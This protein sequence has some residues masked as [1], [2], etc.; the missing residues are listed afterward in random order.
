MNSLN[1]DRA[2]ALPHKEDIHFRPSA[3]EMLPFLVISQGKLILILRSVRVKLYI[4]KGKRGTSFKK[5]NKNR[6]PLTLKSFKKMR[7]SQNF[8][9]PH[10]DQSNITLAMNLYLVFSES[11]W[12]H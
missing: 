2:F 5:K 7:G 4:S 1:A 12:L 10:T 8:Y 11:F 3:W 6:I 9:F